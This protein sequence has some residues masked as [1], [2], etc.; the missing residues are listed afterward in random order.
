[1]TITECIEQYRVLSDGNH[2]KDV[3][4]SLAGRIMNKRTSSSKLYFYDLNGGGLK[5]QVMADARDSYMDEVEFAKYHSG[6]KRGDVVGIC[7]YPGK[8]KRGELSVFPKR[9]MVLSPCLH[10]MPRKK[11]GP[12]VENT[13]VKKNEG[14]TAPDIW[15][16]GM[17]RNPETYVLKDQE[18]RYR[19]R[20]LMLNHEVRQ[21]FKT[22][23]KIINYIRD[24]LNKLDFLEVETPMM[25]MIA[26]GAAVKP[27]VTHHNEL[28]MKL[29]MRIA[30]ELYLKEL[31]VGGLD[32]VYEIGK[33]F[34]NEGIDLTRN[35]EF[36]TC[37]FY[38]A[39]SD[40][41][42][43]MALTE[44]MLS[45]MFKVLTGGYK[46]KY[47]ANGV[48]KDP[49]EMDFTPPFRRIDMI[50]ELETMA[51]LTIPKDLSSEEANKYLLDACVKFDLKCPP[52]QTTAR[53]LDKLVGHFLEET[54]VNPT[55]IINHPEIM[56]PLA[57]WH[58]SKP[59]LTERFELFINKHEVCNA[60]TELNDPVVQHQQ[61]AE[62]LK[63]VLIFPTMKRQDEPSTK[64]SSI[65]ILSSFL[66]TW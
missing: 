30:P 33:Q 43:L 36:T 25:N 19:Q 27:F 48:D 24:F 6:V 51:N 15:V 53:L 5:V 18:T 63:E 3:E 66:G 9:F 44:E 23:S 11:A 28:N 55:F 62:Q 21:I 32:R 59:G 29:F 50:E 61:F 38:M 58:R 16:P 10:M 56:S 22:R 65:L 64:G 60:Y 1:M 45:G 31:V 14:K 34:R 39:F 46:I 54:C 57:K 8:S 49:I 4:V 26:G 13:S 47:H 35:P 20:Y 42:D 37:E 52:P 17:T 12:G 40:Y 2:L 41:N 7:G